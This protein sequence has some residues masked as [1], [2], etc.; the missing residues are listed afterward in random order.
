MEL[1]QEEKSAIKALESLARRWPRT[2]WLYTLNGG[3]SVMKGNTNVTVVDW[4][5]NKTVDS[6]AT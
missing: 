1:T 6:S 4:Q 2:L 3:L 5:A